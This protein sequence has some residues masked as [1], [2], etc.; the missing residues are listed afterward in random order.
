M[1]FALHKGKGK[2]IQQIYDL[3]GEDLKKVGIEFK[4][5]L[6][7]DI[8]LI[9]KM[10]EYILENGGKRIRPLLVLLSAK[11]CNYKGESHIPFASIVE[12]IHT[13]TLLQDDVVEEADLR[14]GNASAN[15]VWGNGASVLVGDFL[16][17]K[18]FYLMI[19]H[20]DMEILKVIS[21]TTTNMSEGE[22]LQLLKT[23]DPETTEDE[24]LEI[25]KNKTA[26]LM[27][28]ACRIGAILGRVSK[29]RKDALAGFGLNIGM[30]FQLTDDCLG[31][32]SNNKELGKAVGNDL[33]EGKITM[34]LIH[35][36][37]N[38]SPDEKEELLKLIGTSSIEDTRLMYVMNLINR[39]KSVEYAMI[40]A[41]N[42]LNDAKICLDVFEPSAERS[43]LLGLADYVFERRF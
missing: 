11:L 9:R 15:T 41:R 36:L 29:E 43:A 2:M 1:G 5:N 27:S 6:H 7:S 25:V 22:I 42:Y 17:A 21:K 3:L 24:Y 12:F 33:K 26:I 31:Y 18:S 23:S 4:K 20:G 37:K 38:S 40:K 39:Y 30:A 28:S 8:F 35:L 32:T 10:G 13:A 34:P 14:R 19:E 16:Y